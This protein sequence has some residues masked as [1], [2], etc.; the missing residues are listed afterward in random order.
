MTTSRYPCDLCG[1]PSGDDAPCCTMCA[2]KAVAALRQVA[3]WLA[4]D[5]ITATAKQ[6]ALGDGR[7]GGKPTK[8]SEAPMPI[9]PRVSEAAAVLRSTLSTWARVL[10]AEIRVDITGPACRTCQHRSCLA[11]RAARLPAD[12]TA[13]MAAWLAPLVRRARHRPYAA[14]LV[15]EVTAAVAQAVRAVDR[16]IRYVPLPDACRMMTLDGETPRPCG[17]AL[18]AVIAPGLPIHDQVRCEESRDHTTTVD[19]EHKARRR[20]ARVAARLARA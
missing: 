7:G 19:E 3:E 9:D 8:A 4:N 15:D 20:A 17:G 2:D 18:R 11:L 5:L 14:E 16:P 6:T 10:H 13:A 1:T 12:T